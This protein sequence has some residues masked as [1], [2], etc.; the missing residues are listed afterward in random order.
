MALCGSTVV[1]VFSLT[2]SGPALVIRQ[3][4]DG[5]VAVRELALLRRQSSC[6]KKSG[7]AMFRCARR[8]DA[9]RCY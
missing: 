9:D 4:V 7:A 6:G 5:L 3:E 1:G 8:S 2:M